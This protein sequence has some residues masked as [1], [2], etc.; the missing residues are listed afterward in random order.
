MHVG[1]AGVEELQRQEE[2]LPPDLAMLSQPQAVSLGLVQ[3]WYY[4]P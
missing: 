1:E 3:S 4:F 2:G